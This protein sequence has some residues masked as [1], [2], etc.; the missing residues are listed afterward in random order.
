M[1]N[2]CDKRIVRT[3]GGELSLGRLCPSGPFIVYLMQIEMFRRDDV[4][5]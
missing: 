4:P 3:E 2:T 1:L 5:D